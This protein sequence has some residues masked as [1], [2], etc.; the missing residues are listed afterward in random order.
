[1]EKP[2]RSMPS[3]NCFR[4]LSASAFA[5]SLFLPAVGNVPGWM[6]MALGPV[7]WFVADSPNFF[8]TLI[9]SVSWLANLV[10]PASWLS[11]GEKSP[12]H[13]VP[14]AIA[15]GLCLL[16]LLAPPLTPD[17]VELCGG[18]TSLGPGFWLWCLSPALL[19]VGE[20]W[21][22]G[23]DESGLDRLCGRL[24]RVLGGP[25][26]LKRRPPVS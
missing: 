8:A 1:M 24:W 14:I 23:S 6:A 15:L 26:N 11:A 10:L 13:P 25:W 17:G 7:V 20:K 4:V 16:F 2:R 21:G 22:G 5:A 9:G 18:E 3:R 12:A 19:L